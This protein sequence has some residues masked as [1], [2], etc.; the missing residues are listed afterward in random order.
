MCVWNIPTTDPSAEFSPLKG[1]QGK[2]RRTAAAVTPIDPSAIPSGYFVFGQPLQMFGQTVQ[3]QPPRTLF[4]NSIFSQQVSSEGIF[5][6]RRR[7][8]KTIHHCS[9]SH[10][11]PTDPTL[12]FF[13]PFSLLSF[14]S[15]GPTSAASKQHDGCA[16]SRNIRCERRIARS[17][18]SLLQ[19][20]GSSYSVSQ[21][22]CFFSF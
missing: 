13:L 19:V 17:S 4:P 9:Q 21:T 20:A 14:H 12:S 7:R 11:L 1:W 22:P 10:N 6:R 15:K 18:C 16:N 3:L 5:R 2:R 8:R